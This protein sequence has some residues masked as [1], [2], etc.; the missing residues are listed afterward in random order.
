MTRVSI[1][2]VLC[3][4][5]AVGAM[6]KSKSNV[7]DVTGCLSKGDTAKEFLIK[8]NDGSTW[9][10]RSSRVALSKHIGHT[11]TA[12]GAVSNAKMHNMKEDAKDMA[13]DSGMK[14]GNTEHGHMTITNVKMV[15]ESC[16]P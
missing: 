2:I 1:S 13:K 14:E 7:R 15:S 11:V 8:G 6:A 12:T 3:L 9:E 10:V 5:I 4:I 16:N